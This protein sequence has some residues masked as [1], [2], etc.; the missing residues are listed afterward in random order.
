MVMVME[1]INFTSVG[2]FWTHVPPNV[3][4]PYFR[5]LPLPGDFNYLGTDEPVVTAQQAMDAD[6]YEGYRDSSQFFRY[7]CRRCGMTPDVLSSPV[8][9]GSGFGITYTHYK[10]N[11]RYFI[12][13][14]R[15]SRSLLEAEPGVV[16]G[17]GPKDDEIK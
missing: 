10:E 7:A 9:P 8:V 4:Q 13:V 11:G 14:D 3:V 16:N 6:G 17:S 12:T 5:Y 15:E 1:I 2:P